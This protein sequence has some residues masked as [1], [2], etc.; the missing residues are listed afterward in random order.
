[1][2]TIEKI[3]QT[4]FTM[5]REAQTRGEQYNL[6]TEDYGD[7]VV[8]FGKP[9]ASGMSSRK[10]DYLIIQT[11]QGRIRLPAEVVAWINDAISKL[12][13]P[14]RDL[15]PVNFCSY[16]RTMVN[17]VQASWY[18]SESEN[19]LADH[20]HN[21]LRE[22]E[23]H[24]PVTMH[25]PG[26]KSYWENWYKDRSWTDLT[27]IQKFPG[28]SLYKE[29]NFE[30]ISE[31]LS[32]FR[33]EIRARRS[34]MYQRYTWYL[35]NCDDKKF[36]VF[37]VLHDTFE[38]E[39][40]MLS[41]TSLENMANASGAS[42]AEGKSMLPDE[43]PCMGI[44]DDKTFDPAL[45][46][47]DVESLIS[48]KRD[49][50]IFWKRACGCSYPDIEKESKEIAEKTGWFK[51]FGKSLAQERYKLIEPVLG[52]LELNDKQGLEAVAL[53]LAGEFLIG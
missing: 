51:P 21:A 25:E 50:W 43:L 46:R 42:D 16:F 29:V 14:R 19:A 22:K 20:L 26:R 52:E 32:Q 24:N 4:L 8:Y 12:I 28:V 36:L 41:T 38:N 44:M 39:L 45:V 2:D 6:T 7:L 13:D 11:R 3:L 53:A 15:N 1:M 9:L 35:L 27:G 47:L 34:A 18:R 48:A 23:N 30:P 40:G 10:M 5:G 33:D 17:S 49:R 31:V 37:K